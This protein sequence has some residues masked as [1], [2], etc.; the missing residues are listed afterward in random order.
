MSS[1]SLIAALLTS[2]LLITAAACGGG[3]PTPSPTPT[4]EGPAAV[5]ANG[6]TVSVHY[7]GTLDSGVEF[8]SSR[9]SAP[10]VFTVGSGQMIPGFDEA[11]RGLAVG[12]TVTVR[13]EPGRAYGERL[14]E[15]V[16]DIPSEQAPGGL[17]P[18]DTIQFSNGGTAVVLEVTDEAVRVDANHRLAG[19]TLTFEIELVSIR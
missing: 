18:G 17:L 12:D 5:A 19:Q 11:V 8:D 4:P 7:R 3:E 2:L 13:L 1:Y 6:D 15:L 10:L 9:G 16:F 14:D